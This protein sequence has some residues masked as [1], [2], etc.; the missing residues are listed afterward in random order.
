MIPERII[1][2][3]ASYCCSSTSWPSYIHN[4]WITVIFHSASPS[5]NVFCHYI[6]WW[7]YLVF[8]LLQLSKKKQSLPDK[9]LQ[10][11]LSYCLLIS[12]SIRVDEHIVHIF[13]DV[14]WVF[15]IFRVPVEKWENTLV[16]ALNKQQRVGSSQTG[17]KYTC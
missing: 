5:I 14:P 7:I 15:T 12:S 1:G 2:S 8:P 9:S 6:W 16:F 4:I 13:I 11:F 17:K 10:S 3:F